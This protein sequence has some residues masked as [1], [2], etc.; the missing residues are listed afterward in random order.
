MIGTPH[1][2]ERVASSTNERARELAI[3]GAP[4]GT[5]VTADQQTAGRGRQGRRWVAAPGDA[6]LMSLV[7]R[8]R[9]DALALLPLRAAVAVRDTCEQLSGA[10]CEIKWPNDIW[11]ERR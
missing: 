3:A 8:G 2:H 7:V 11:I 6:V 10:H 1:L 5:L 4:H 9:G